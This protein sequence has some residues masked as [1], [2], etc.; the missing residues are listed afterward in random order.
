MVDNSEKIKWWERQKQ[1]IESILEDAE[2]GEHDFILTD[3][4]IDAFKKF[5]A[6]ANRA[7]EFY[8][9]DSRTENIYEVGAK[10]V[11]D[12]NYKCMVY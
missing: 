8:E 7:I 6:L 5:V 11:V 4:E 3:V 9:I 12:N 10:K 2:N 1:D